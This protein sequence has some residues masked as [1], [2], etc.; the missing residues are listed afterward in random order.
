MKAQRD[1]AATLLAQLGDTEPVADPDEAMARAA[2]ALERTADAI[3]QAI[4][5]TPVGE[6]GKPHPLMDAWFKSVD[7]TRQML[8]ALMRKGA[9][10]VAVTVNERG[11]PVAEVFRRVADTLQ[12]WPE[13]AAAVSELALALAT[14]TAP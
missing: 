2:A 4:G 13:A 8:T 10:D 3:A 14:E 5:T 7:Q 9:P 11:M 1:R 12:P 6:N